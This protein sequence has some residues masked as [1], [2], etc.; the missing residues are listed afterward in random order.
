M[1]R[2]KS[3]AY[4]FARYSLLLAA[5]C[6]PTAFAVSLTVTPTVIPGNSTSTG[7][8]VCLGGV[9]PGLWEGPIRWRASGF[10]SNTNS[11]QTI[12]GIG[13]S[14]DIGYPGSD[15][16]I[17]NI[18]AFTHGQGPNY[19]RPNSDKAAFYFTYTYS[20][21]AF[22]ASTSETVTAALRVDVPE[23]PISVNPS[24]VSGDGTRTINLSLVAP[25]PTS[26]AEVPVSVTCQTYGGMGANITP[27]STVTDNL[28]RA[29][30]TLKTTGSVVSWPLRY[31]MAA[32]SG[33]C[34][35]S[36]PDQTSVGKVNLVGRNTCAT[37][38]SPPDP[39]CN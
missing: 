14:G 13:G 9:S 7:I 20:S 37:P 27:M 16:C 28:G 30:F 11:T 26:T 35:F 39:S 32:P 6:S 17:R 25:S 36:L 23:M 38:T 4:R 18:T 19:R 15:G 34:T 33:F 8:S 31:G 29:S 1:N 2:V 21:H 24:S 10:Y 5:L 12:N 3:I 22:P